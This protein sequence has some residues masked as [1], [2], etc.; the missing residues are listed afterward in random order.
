MNLLR[1]ALLTFA[2]G[3][4]SSNTNAAPGEYWEITNK[5]EMAGMPF[6]MPATTQKLCIPKGAENDPKSTAGDKNCQM[7]D[8]KTVGKK[9]TWKARCNHDGEVM[10]GIGEQTGSKDGYKGKIQFSGKSDGEDIN[11]KMEFSGKRIGGNCDTEET[12]KKIKAQLCDTSNLESTADWVSASDIFLAKDSPC[13]EQR[14]QLCENV[15]KD[16]PK[17]AQTFY[18]LMMHD[19]QGNSRVSVAKECKLDMPAITKSVCKTI[20]GKNYGQL[21]AYCPA[22][23]KNYRETVRR[24]ECE[25]RS[26]TAETREEDIRKC[27]KNISD[28][29]SDEYSS[30]NTPRRKSG[31]KDA[32]EESSQQQENSG[33]S[34]S[35]TTAAD[36]LNGAKK[37][38]GLLG[39]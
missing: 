21:S 35:G 32:Q 5:M 26:Y 25:G 13:L 33:S 12:G 31:R 30:E 37:F 15:R 24:K 7:T 36:I 18:T 27:M 11:M 28:D 19:Q 4:I 39:F 22:E 23:A 1:T 14:K 16:A 29:A 34:S 8:V 3:L 6:A 17:D 38:K 20:N 10:T 2:I 9:T